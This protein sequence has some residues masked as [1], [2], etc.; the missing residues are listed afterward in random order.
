MVML[1]WFVAFA[2]A[3]EPRNWRRPARKSSS[4]V[5]S[6]EATKPAAFTRPVRVIAMPF[7]L[8]R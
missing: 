4:V 3:P 2:E 1:P 5:S 7:G 6:V 8:T